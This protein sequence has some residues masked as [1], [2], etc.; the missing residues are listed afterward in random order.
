MSIS[1]S[2]S[3]T[4]GAARYHWLRLAAPGSGWLTA[5]C[6]RPQRVTFQEQEF[7]VHPSG[8]KS[9]K[10]GWLAGRIFQPNKRVKRNKLFISLVTRELARGW[11]GWKI[12]LSNKLGKL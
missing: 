7:S 2:E 10:T 8:E 4:E 5:G 1:S 3:E 12:E 11:Q 9:G 6:L